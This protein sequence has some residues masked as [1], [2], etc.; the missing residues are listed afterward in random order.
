M[1]IFSFDNNFQFVLQKK[2]HYALYPPTKVLKNV[3]SLCPRQY[4]VLIIFHI[5]SLTDE[6]NVSI[7]AETSGE[8]TLLEKQKGIICGGWREGRGMM[9][10]ET[11]GDSP[12]DDVE[13]ELSQNV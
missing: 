7:N 4:Q 5:S 8:L 6:E 9:L 10:K 1:C 13:Q 3:F 11:L 2:T 12:L